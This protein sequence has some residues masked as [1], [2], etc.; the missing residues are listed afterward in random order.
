MADMWDKVNRFVDSCL[1]APPDVLIAHGIHLLAVDRLR[2]SGRPIPYLLGEADRANTLR[3][4]A[5]RSLLQRVRALL[6]GPMVL[7]KGP[8]VAQWYPAPTL[9][10][11][12][13]LD[14]LVPD[15]TTA[16]LT[17]LS[18]GFQEVRDYEFSHTQRP[19]RWPGLPLAIELHHQLPWLPWGVAPCPE[20][21]FESRVPSTTGIEGITTLPAA[22][23]AVFVA[24]HA[25]GHAPLRRLN[26]VIDVMAIAQGVGSERVAARATAMGMG[27]VW[28]T[29]VGAANSLFDERASDSVPLKTWARH[30]YPPRERS[31]SEVHIARWIGSLWAPTLRGKV[32]SL[33]VTLRDDLEPL[34]GEP[35]REKWART[36]RAVREADSPALLRPRNANDELSG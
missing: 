33:I 11:Y 16:R 22:D 27:N 10:A 4:L 9:R 31:V 3:Y 35:W 8:E 20:S 25:W 17:L 15:S 14:I 7:V 24:V 23:H 6:D 2:S 26:D 5:G 28:S 21:L 13:D 32:R 36:S 19:L 34:P 30:L 29:T 1:D 18:A 12:G